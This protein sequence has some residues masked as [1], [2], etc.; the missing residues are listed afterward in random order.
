MQQTT[1]NYGKMKIYMFNPDS[2]CA[3]TILSREL[4]TNHVGIRRKSYILTTVF[5]EIKYLTCRVHEN[6]FPFAVH[7]IIV[8]FSKTFGEPKCKP[9]VCLHIRNESS[10][11]LQ[12]L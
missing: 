5:S 6:A 9:I 8:G 11:Y 2:S 3:C 12:R 4:N 7:G 10:L 1:Y